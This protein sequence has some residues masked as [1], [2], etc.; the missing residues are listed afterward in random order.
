M[1]NHLLCC[2]WGTSSFRL[3]LIDLSDHQIA[4]EVLSGEGIANTF[5]GWQVEAGESGMVRGRFFR[6]YL[7]KQIDIL[8]ARLSFDLDGI[9][10]VIS[11]MASSSIGMEEIP[12][13]NLPYATDGSRAG[14]RYF[15]AAADFSHEILLIS[16]V[17]S[18]LDA[19]RGEETQL[20][21]LVNLA[22]LS[23]LKNKDAIFIFP[24]THSKHMYVK[25]D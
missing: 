12:Y 22:E 5:N 21:G 24:G 6:D 17:K 18:E 3:R 19:M 4:G 13:E 15:E 7:K 10:I 1:K 16:G 14:I 8:S 23:S 2:D 20:V 9:T 11:G 25:E